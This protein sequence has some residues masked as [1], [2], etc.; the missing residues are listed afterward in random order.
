[1]IDAATFELV[2]LWPNLGK[3]VG[4]RTYQKLK[5]HQNFVKIQCA[6]SKIWHDK[7]ST[8][9]VVSS[10]CVRT[11]KTFKSTWISKTVFKVLKRPWKLQ[12]SRGS[13]KRPWIL[14]WQAWLSFKARSS[15]RAER[16]FVE[17]LWRRV[18]IE[19]RAG[20]AQ[21]STRSC[22]GRRD[23]WAGRSRCKTVDV[24]RAT[25]EPASW[26]CVGYRRLRTD[27]ENDKKGMK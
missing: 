22:E 6:V 4:H 9:T 8:T 27:G 26:P 12:K 7:V 19:A 16:Q 11:L 24:D 3:N 25:L 5:L 18:G 1:M 15:L 23:A 2:R 21:G 17:N 13:L 10:G 14:A 20:R